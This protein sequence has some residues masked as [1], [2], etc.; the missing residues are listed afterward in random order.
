MC[1]IAYMRSRPTG[2]RIITGIDKELIV[3]DQIIIACVITP[4]RIE[5]GGC[6]DMMYT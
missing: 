5:E 6:E 4:C 1:T 2:S 3:S